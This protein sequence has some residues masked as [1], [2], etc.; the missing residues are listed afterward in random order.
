MS[1]EELMASAI[2]DFERHHGK[3]TDTRSYMDFIRGE[4]VVVVETSMKRAI[5]SHRLELIKIIN[6]KGVNH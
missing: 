6:L 1:D 3:H 5:Y 2:L 4:P